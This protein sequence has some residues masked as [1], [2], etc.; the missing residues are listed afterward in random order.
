MCSLNVIKWFCVKSLRED[1]EARRSSQILE[2]LKLITPHECRVKLFFYS[3][4]ENWLGKEVKEYVESHLR[5]TYTHTALIISDKF[6]FAQK[7]VKL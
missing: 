1:L 7:R 6:T 4:A 5:Y 2:G 3:F